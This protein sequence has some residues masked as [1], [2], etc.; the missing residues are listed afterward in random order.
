MRLNPRALLTRLPFR[1][2]LAMAFSG[3]FLLAGILLLAFVVVLARYGTSQQVQGI[4]VTYG[5]DLPTGTA[6]PSGPYTPPARTPRS[7]PRAMSP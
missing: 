7:I 6:T 1:A 4:S 2:R 3:L 5:G